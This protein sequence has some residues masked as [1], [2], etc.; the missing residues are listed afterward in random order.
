[1]SLLSFLA[2]KKK[3]DE[4]SVRENERINF[5]LKHIESY[6]ERV[7]LSKSFNYA[8]ATLIAKN[9]A[10]IRE[11]LEK[12]RITLSKDFHFVEDS[13]KNA[14][15]ILLDI[16]N[17]HTDQ[18]MGDLMHAIVD[19]K[20]KEDN[21]RK[22]FVEMERIISAELRLITVI[23]NTD[24]TKTNEIEKLLLELYKLIYEREV[25]VNAV[26]RTEM[27]GSESKKK[28]ERV[29]KA[30]GQLII[31]QKVEEL[32]E[33]EAEIFARK[34]TSKLVD[35]QGNTRYH[36]LAMSIFKTLC[37]LAGYPDSNIDVLDVTTRIGKYMEKDV[38]MRD[39]ITKIRPDLK[40][41]EIDGIIF[42]FREVYGNGHFEEVVSDIARGKDI[43][44]Y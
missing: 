32:A 8:K 15:E 21:L 6:K 23:L 22:M 26:F 43:S 9:P 36:K 42:A 19:E 20:N 10:L 16:A 3:T 1:M 39:I 24:S 2:G 34:V 13:D 33:S 12:I 28:H 25:E 30:V 44:C 35:P 18:I 11:V 40:S 5:F 4:I 41:F 14:T 31:G 37:K 17:L 27:Y 29:M 7:N 38:I